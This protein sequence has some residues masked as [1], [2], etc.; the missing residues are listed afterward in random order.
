MRSKESLRSLASFLLACLLSC[1][2]LR[3]AHAQ[4]PAGGSLSVVIRPEALVSVPPSVIGAGQ[5]DQ[6]QPTGQHWEL[7][8][9]LP[10]SVKIRLAQG[11]AADLAMDMS[12]DVAQQL[13]G[14]ESSEIQVGSFTEVFPASIPV[15]NSGVHS[16]SA[17]ITLRGVGTL[18]QGAV[19]VRV[20][21]RSQ[22]GAIEWTQT[23]QLV[24]TAAAA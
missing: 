11:V 15:D 3:S 21:L 5:T 23:V 12:G 4:G 22:D 10:I 16:L 13:P 17:V 2:L 6:T 20:T 9:D 18:P 7:R 8:F 14:Y 24:W 19:P 1:L